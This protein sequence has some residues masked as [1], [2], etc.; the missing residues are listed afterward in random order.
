MV[1]TFDNISDPVDRDM[2]TI[3]LNPN[4]ASQAPIVNI[5]IE[6]WGI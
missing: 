1:A 6:I 3:I 5:I 4:L 2:I